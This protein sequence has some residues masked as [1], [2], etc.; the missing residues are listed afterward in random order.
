MLD[1][2]QGNDKVNNV[3]QFI[4]KDIKKWYKFSFNTICDDVPL[5]FTIHFHK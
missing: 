5:G 3:F 1:T 4:K 2:M